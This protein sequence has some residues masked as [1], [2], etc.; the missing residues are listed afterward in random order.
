[1]RLARLRKWLNSV[2][3]PQVSNSQPD[4]AMMQLQMQMQVEQM[5]ADLKRYELDS[6]TMVKREKRPSSQQE[7]DTRNSRN[8]DLKNNEL[9]IDDDEG[10]SRKPAGKG[11]G[12]GD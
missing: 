11:C 3:K 6:D 10:T 5:K 2:S 4:P 7:V 12:S 9:Q 8:L 1:M